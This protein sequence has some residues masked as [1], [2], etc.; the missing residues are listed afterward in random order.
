ALAAIGQQAAA[1]HLPWPTELTSPPAPPRFG[2]GSTTPPSLPGKG[3]GGLGSDAAIAALWA[4]LLELEER[5]I[6][7]GLH[8]IGRPPRAAELCDLLLQVAAY[9]R[10]EHDLPALP[11]L[12]ADA[13]GLA[14]PDTGL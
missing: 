12:I 9:P 10:P 8:E 5:L 6:P 1:L 13:L 3:A 4:A 7:V 2:E 14:L 11:T